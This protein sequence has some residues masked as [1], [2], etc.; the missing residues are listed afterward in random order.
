M[1][2]DEIKLI[3]EQQAQIKKGYDYQIKYL[4]ECI[5]N[6]TAE[7]DQLQQDKKQLQLQVQH[8]QSGLTGEEVDYL[9]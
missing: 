7:R 9:Q 2:K 3:K 4:E 1:T 6:V 8:L 5:K